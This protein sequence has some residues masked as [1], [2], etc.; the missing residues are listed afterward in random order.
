MKTIIDK[1]LTL[2]VYKNGLSDLIELHD[3]DDM[4]LIDVESIDKLIETLTNI[5]QFLGEK[6]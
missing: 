1:N 5:K 4:V 3:N 6:E 2:K